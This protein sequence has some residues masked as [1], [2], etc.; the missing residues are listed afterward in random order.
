MVPRWKRVLST[1]WVNFLYQWKRS[2]GAK[3]VIGFIALVEFFIAWSLINILPFIFSNETSDVKNQILLFFLTNFTLSLNSLLGGI[4]AYDPNIGLG[5]VRISF[6][7]PLGIFTTLAVILLGAGLFSDD[8]QY[9]VIEVYL[10][11]M[12]KIDYIISKYLA[13]F[14]PSLLMFALSPFI[15]TLY[16]VTSINGLKLEVIIQLIIAQIIY[17]FGLS[18]FITSLT[19]L[20][21]AHSSRRAYAGMLIFF[22][23]FFLSFSTQLALSTQGSNPGTNISDVEWLILID[24]FLSHQAWGAYLFGYKY[25]TL[26]S[27]KSNAII[28][29]ND[30]KGLEWWHPLLT[31]ISI[32]IIS[33]I[34][35][36]REMMK[37]LKEVAY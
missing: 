17:Q 2:L 25:I 24:P 16:A 14:I 34:L 26:S 4:N 9:R 33:W 3:I 31:L 6:A 29:L 27:F 1:A 19:L 37:K 20:A 8:T 23:L 11:R 32:T 15:I 18:I 5:D 10:T 12:D 30:G 35:T 22:I 13:L 21:S 28:R 36:I 7:L